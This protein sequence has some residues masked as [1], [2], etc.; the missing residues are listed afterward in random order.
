MEIIERNIAEVF[1]YEKNPR[2]NDQAVDAIMKSI[3]QFGFNSPIIVD[4]NGVIICGHTRYKAALRLGLQTV[5]VAVASELS[6]EQVKAYRIADNK[7]AELATW[8]Y[9]MLISEIET[10]KDSGIDLSLLDFEIVDMNQP[11]TLKE[12]KTDANAVPDKPEE[13]VSRR[14]EIYQLGEH[15][16]MCG[17]STSAVDMCLLMDGESANLYL[18]DPPYNVAVTCAAGKTI[19]NDNMSSSSFKAFLTNAFKTAAEV[20][21]AN[22]MLYI[23]F[24]SIEH[25]NFHLAADEAGLDIKQ[26]L[27]WIKS[28]FILGHQDYH[29]KCEPCMYGWK[30]GGHYVWY[31]Q[32]QASNLFRYKKPNVN[33]DHPTPKP[34]EML[35][36]LIRNSSRRGEI[37]LDS[38]GGSGSTLIACEQTGRVCRAME[39]DEKYCDVIRKRYAEFINGEGCDWASLTPA[40]SEEIANAD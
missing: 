22:C 30:R 17:D 5:P 33:K 10:L 32:R 40:I 11:E 18:T 21:D 1:P 2:V 16:L 6:P 28:H 36:E 3:S 34:V 8:N 9:D 26:E 14:G 7:L 23:F 15:R 4:S 38:F 29:Y 24:A 27:Y 39:L 31:G 35:V 25:V 37:V 19:Q 13:A 20:M 12:G